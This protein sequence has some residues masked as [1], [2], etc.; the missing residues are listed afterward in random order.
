MRLERPF[1]GLL[2]DARRLGEHSIDVTDGLLDVAMH[3]LGL[4][5]VLVDSGL[6]RERRLG[7]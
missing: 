5:D 3:D 4:A 7:V 1:V 6:A 2:D